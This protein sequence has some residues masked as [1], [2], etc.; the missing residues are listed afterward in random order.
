MLGSPKRRRS[1]VAMGLVHLNGLPQKAEVISVGGEG[2]RL[3]SSKQGQMQASAGRQRQAPLERWLT[4]KTD[5]SA[6]I[7]SRDLAAGGCYVR[8]GWLRL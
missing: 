2:G 6:L 7:L 8:P 1:D 5:P 3:V 4:R